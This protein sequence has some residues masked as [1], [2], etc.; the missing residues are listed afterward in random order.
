[1]WKRKYFI[2]FTPMAREQNGGYGHH[3]HSSHQN[4]VTSAT[5][6]ALTTTLTPAIYRGNITTKIDKEIASYYV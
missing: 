5:E 2:F 3:I 6:V 4:M 1:M